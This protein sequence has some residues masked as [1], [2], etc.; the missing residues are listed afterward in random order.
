MT[1]TDSQAAE[2]SANTPL[3]PLLV[4]LDYP[5]PPGG[6]QTLVRELKDGLSAIGNRPG[7]LHVDTSDYDWGPTDLIPDPAFIYGHRA[8]T[9]GDFRYFNVLYRKVKHAIDVFDP[10]VVHA[11]HQKCWPALRAAREA[12]I[13]CLV[14]V[15]ALELTNQGL[16]EKAL[17]EADVV[18]AVSNWTAGLVTGLSPE[19]IVDVRYPSID[20]EAYRNAT[21]TDRDEN[22]GLVTISRIGEYKNVTRLVRAWRELPEEVRT[23][24]EFV[25]AGDGKRRDAVESAASGASDIRLTGWVSEERKRKLL[26]AADAFALCPLNDGFRTEGFGIVFVEAQ[27]AGLPV[28]GS[29]AGG[30]REAIGSGGIAVERPKSDSEIRDALVSVLSDGEQFRRAARRRVGQFDRD[31]VARQ[32]ARTYRWMMKDAETES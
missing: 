14:S 32:H 23:G 16:A 18:H 5:P 27:A 28:V 26:A 11:L 1:A 10:D 12:G 4:T 9:S 7:L 22:V 20:V 30:A 24:R 6:I 19:S 3:S 2:S 29:C 17:G 8:L 21:P 31:H 13:P 25:I 15:H